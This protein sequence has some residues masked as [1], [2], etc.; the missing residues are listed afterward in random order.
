MNPLWSQ[1]ERIEILVSDSEAV[2]SE[3]SFR[4]LREYSTTFPTGVYAGKMWKAAIDDGREIRWVLRWYGP[5][6]DHACII[7]QR[8]IQIMDWKKL[9]GV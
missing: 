1:P 8:P 2:M 9:M 5:E 6:I 4:L 7:H 3:Q